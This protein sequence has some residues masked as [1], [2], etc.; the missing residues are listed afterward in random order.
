MKSPLKVS[1]IL[2]SFAVLLFSANVMGRHP[3]CMFVLRDDGTQV[4]AFRLQLPLAYKEPVVE[5]L[6]LSFD[7]KRQARELLK[8]ADGRSLRFFSAALGK[9]DAVCGMSGEKQEEAWPSYLGGGFR[10][11]F[12]PSPQG[13]F[14]DLNWFDRAYLGFYTKAPPPAPF[15]DNELQ[16]E[17][18]PRPSASA[19][20]MASPVPAASPVP[21]VGVLR[22]EIL[23]GCGITNAADW[24]A[25]KFQGH[26][27]TI[28]STGNADH[29]HYPKTVIRTAVGVPVALEEAVERLGLSQDSIEEVSALSDPMD[30]AVIVGRDY[31]KLK[32]HKR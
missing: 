16:V 4:E 2:L 27:I 18:P 9:F 7:Q 22:V 8:S 28:V 24:A 21:L 32:R 29:F 30:V 12:Q 6:R 23:N 17:V 19:V 1:L 5:A 14:D 3:F 20:P 26:G 13:E 10:S 11:L 31:P 25:R 15:V